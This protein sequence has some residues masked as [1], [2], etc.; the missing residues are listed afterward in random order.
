MRNSIVSMPFRRRKM[1]CQSASFV[2]RRRAGRRTDSI[3]IA[4]Q[5]IVLMARIAKCLAPA[6]TNRSIEDGVTFVRYRPLDNSCKSCHGETQV[7]E[8]KKD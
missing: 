7:Q 3:T 6:V 8:L 4:I 1:V 5:H 2:T